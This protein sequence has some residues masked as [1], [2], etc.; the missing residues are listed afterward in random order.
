MT[1][2]SQAD[3]CARG[4]AEVKAAAPPC[5]KRSVVLRPLARGTDGTDV[6]IHPRVLASAEHERPRS[7]RDRSTPRRG[8]PD[9]HLL[10]VEPDRDLAPGGAAPNQHQLEP[11]VAPEA[12]TDRDRRDRR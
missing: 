10:Q 8:E 6:G 7:A 3:G 1:A 4:R 9:V 12:E 5:P 11:A 2:R